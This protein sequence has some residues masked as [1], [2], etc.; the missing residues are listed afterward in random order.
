MKNLA[1]LI[2]SFTFSFVGVLVLAG[3]AALLRAW[4]DTAVL[5]PP[6]DFPSLA[7]VLAPALP[8]AFYCSLLFAISYSSRRRIPYAVSLIAL[9]ALSLGF[10]MAAS[11]GLSR[12][13]KL[14]PPRPKFPAVSVQPGLV[15]TVTPGDPPARAVLTGTGPESARI[16][17]LP[18]QALFFEP[19]SASYTARRIRLPFREE[20]NAAPGISADFAGSARVFRA[21]FDAGPAPFAVYAGSLGLFL[22]SLGCLV[23]I[24]FWPLANLFFGALAFRGALAL[25]RFLNAGETHRL[26]SSFAG[27]LIPESLVNPIIFGV[28]GILILLYSGLVYLARG[29]RSE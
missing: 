10:A 9:L 6:A 7:A 12:L 20:R 14:S 16:L 29:R 4:A 5:F 18:G 24:S 8:A 11:T 26:L 2:L 21:W 28:L 19:A 1:K 22:V 15:L 23:N 13:E 27:N 3:L 25:E 17:S